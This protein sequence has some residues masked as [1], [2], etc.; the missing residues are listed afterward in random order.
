[1]IYD[2]K[3]PNSMEAYSW[4]KHWT[5]R[6][7]FHLAPQ[8]L[9]LHLEI[10]NHREGWGLRIESRPLW[11]FQH[12]LQHVRLPQGDLVLEPQA[13]LGYVE[14]RLLKSNASVRWVQWTWHRRRPRPPGHQHVQ[15]KQ[16]SSATRNLPKLLKKNKNQTLSTETWHNFQIICPDIP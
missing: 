15:P 4:E 12:S 6:G 13:D 11:F 1:M 2:G 14:S 5:T 3:S 16:L 7:I 9:Y 10:E 8:L